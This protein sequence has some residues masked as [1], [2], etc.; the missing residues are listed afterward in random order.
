MLEGFVLSVRLL[1][2]LSSSIWSPHLGAAVLWLVSCAVQCDEK[3]RSPQSD[4]MAP[5]MPFAKWECHRQLRARE[6]HVEIWGLENKFSHHL[7]LGQ[8]NQL[9]SVLRT[10]LAQ[11]P[12]LQY[13]LR[14][15][16]NRR[17]GHSPSRPASVICK[18]LPVLK[19]L[20]SDACKCKT[21]LLSWAWLARRK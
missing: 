10:F 6:I 13:L 5:A 15:R 9:I 12:C 17:A 21:V 8:G 4:L 18:A 3:D 16:Q 7:D 2:P 19:S 1:I 20:Y 14:P 11:V